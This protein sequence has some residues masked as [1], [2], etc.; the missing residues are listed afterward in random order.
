MAQ[1]VCTQ[2]IHTAGNRSTYIG[3]FFD[4]D[5]QI[6]KNSP[7]VFVTLEEWAPGETRTVKK[8]RK[9]RTTKTESVEVEDTGDATVLG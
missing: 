8:P 4:S 1:M 3:Q 6:V 5:D 9:K 7:T 2:V